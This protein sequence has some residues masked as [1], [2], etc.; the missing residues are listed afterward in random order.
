MSWTLSAFDVRNDIIEDVGDLNFCKSSEKWIFFPGKRK[1]FD[2]DR[3]CISHGG[4]IIVPRFELISQKR[5]GYIFLKIFRSKTLYSNSSLI[6]EFKGTK[7]SNT[8]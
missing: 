1:Y 5:F 8:Q 4:W 7:V 2:A 3:L 6:L